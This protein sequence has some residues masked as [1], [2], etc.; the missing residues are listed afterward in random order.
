METL[1]LKLSLGGKPFLVPRVRT[2]RIVRF[3]GGTVMGG[4]WG[5]DVTPT[6]G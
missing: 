6:G 1:S 4:G 3:R 2:G 5:D